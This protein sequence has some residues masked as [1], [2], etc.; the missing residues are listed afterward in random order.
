MQY[1]FFFFLLISVS[2]SLI[3]PGFLPVLSS[4]YFSVTPSQDINCPP[5]S[6]KTRQLTS[7]SSP[8][9]WCRLAWGTSSSG[10]WLTGDSDRRNRQIDKLISSRGSTTTYCYQT[11]IKIENL[12]FQ[13]ISYVSV[14][15]A[16]FLNWLLTSPPSPTRWWTFFLHL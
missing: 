12:G 3:W 11:L 7:Q 6:S 4:V 9:P 2:S 16:Q 13:L 8:G 1:F 15:E 14:E 10:S 5:A